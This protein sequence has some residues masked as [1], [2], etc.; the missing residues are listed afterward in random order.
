[1]EPGKVLVEVC[2]E[3][4]TQR[5]DNL[6]ANLHAFQG[7]TDARGRELEI[8]TIEEAWEAE[9]TSEIYAASYINFYIANDAVFMPAFGIDRDKN[10][11][12]TVASLFPEREI[13]QLDI[14]GIAPGGGG[15]H[16]ITQQQPVSNLGS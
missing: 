1:V 16:C 6:L 5:Y 8:H 14:R 7:A 10:A 13:V 2:P 12:E 15:I 3:K 4:G 9:T 11:R